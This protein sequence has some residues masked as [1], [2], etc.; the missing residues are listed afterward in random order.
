MGKN[1]D[2]LQTFSQKIQNHGKIAGPKLFAPSPSRQ[3][4][5]FRV[6]SPPPFIKLK[7]VETFHTHTPS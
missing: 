6:P 5:T 2:L 1:F 4:K 7:R 3:G